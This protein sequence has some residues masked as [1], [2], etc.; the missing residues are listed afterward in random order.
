MIELPPVPA[1]QP[2]HEQSGYRP[3]IVVQDDPSQGALPTVV[4][5]PTTTRPGATRFGT[6]FVLTPSPTNGLK[7]PSVVLTF[8]IRA[9]DRARVKK[10]VGRLSE[11]E[12]GELDAR[13][14]NLL[15]LPAH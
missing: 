4:I 5:V 3:A 12:M 15:K 11:S 8:Q 13:L 7:A 10:V 9:L 1:E 6:T 2:T 14:R